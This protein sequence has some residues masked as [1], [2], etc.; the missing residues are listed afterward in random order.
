[1]KMCGYPENDLNCCK[2][3]KLEFRD[4]EPAESG[5]ISWS[6]TLPNI[7]MYW[8]IL[9]N[10]IV[11]CNSAKG[12]EEFNCEWNCMEK[13]QARGTTV[14]EVFISFIPRL[15]EKHFQCHS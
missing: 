3:S 13:E 11:M 4:Y 5:I 14:T 7:T 9:K 8:N 10:S 12:N 2:I 6:K 15:R 1:M